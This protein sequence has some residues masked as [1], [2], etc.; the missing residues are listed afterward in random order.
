M[1]SR[2]GL[3][4]LNC[5]T[6]IK[7]AKDIPFNNREYLSCLKA[8]SPCD[9]CIDVPKP[10]DPPPEFS[11]LEFFDRYLSELRMPNSSSIQ[12]VGPLG[13][14]K[15]ILLRYLADKMRR[16]AS[17]EA[18]LV[19]EFR[20]R[21]FAATSISNRMLLA[22]FLHQLLSQKPLLFYHVQ[23]YQRLCD[24]KRL[25]TEHDLWV[26]VHLIFRHNLE[27]PVIIFI[28]DLDEWLSPPF[29]FL[30]RLVE[31]AAS[32]DST[33]KFVISSK[34]LQPLVTALPSEVVNLGNR[35]DESMDWRQVVER[36][37][38]RL[39]RDRPSCRAIENEILKRISNF[40][41][42]I[43]Q[44]FLYLKQLR[45]INALST[46]EA[47]QR[48][49]QLLPLDIP[50]V[51][52][53]IIQ[54]IHP[55]FLGWALLCL[56]WLIY[57]MRPLKIS[58]FAVA[59]AIT[60]AS[61]SSARIDN[62]IAADL[63]Y[64]LRRVLGPLIRLQTDE[65][66]LIHESVA[67]ILQSYAESH[68]ILNHADIA[69]FCLEYMLAVIN[70]APP[71]VEYESGEPLI[72]SPLTG[73]YMFLNYA[74]RHWPKHYHLA[75]PDDKL[76]QFV[77]GFLDSTSC[78]RKW[79]EMFW[80][81]QGLS[82]RLESYAATELNIACELGLLRVAE[83]LLHRE[84]HG[85]NP[86]ILDE[87][88]DLAVRSD[89]GK[90]ADLL[91]DSGARGVLALHYAARN[92][93]VEMIRRLAKNGSNLN[94]GSNFGSTPLHVS[95]QAGWLEAASVL[96]ECGADPLR[97]DTHGSTALH[98]AASRGFVDIVQLLLAAKISPNAINVYK[99]TPLGSAAFQGHKEVTRVL[100]EAGADV[101]HSDDTKLTPL[102]CA[103]GGGY[104]D[105]VEQ[106]IEF[107][108]DT[109]VLTRRGRTALHIAA[110]E[111]HLDVVK[112]LLNT[113]KTYFLLNIP[114]AVPL[115]AAARNGYFAI[116][117]ELVEA[118]INIEA[119]NEDLS[120]PLH[121]AARGGHTEIV[122]YLLGHG[123]NKN[124]RNRRGLSPLQ[125]GAMHGH[126]ST[127][128][129]LVGSVL[130]G[131]EPVL[132]YAA[133]G[134]HI[135]VVKE[136]LKYGADPNQVDEQKTTPLMAAANKGYSAV[137][138]ELLKTKAE[139]GQLNNRNETPLYLASHNGHVGIVA[140]LLGAGAVVDVRNC[141]GETPLYA[142]VAHLEVVKKLLEAH[143]DVDAPNES[144]STPLHNAAKLGNAGV[145]E[146]LLQN[147]ANPRATNESNETPLH[148][149]SWKGNVAIMKAFL[150]Y[151]ANVNAATYGGATPLHMAADKGNADAVQCLLI[152]S[153]KTEALDDDGSSPLHWAAA[154]GYSRVI[155]MLLDAGANIDVRDKESRTPLFLAARSGLLEAVK[156]LVAREAD[157]QASDEAGWCPLLRAMDNYEVSEF[158]ITSGAEVNV[159]NK[160][161]DS[162]LMM[163]AMVGPPALVELLLEHGADLNMANEDGV[164]PLGFAAENGRTENI[165]LLI[166]KGA[167]INRRGKQ[168][169]TALHLAAANG[170][171]EAMKALIEGGADLNIP[172]QGGAQPIHFATYFG[173]IPALEL[174]VAHGAD[175]TRT[176]KDGETV[177]E[178]SARRGY[179]SL[180]EWILTH[181]ADPAVSAN[182]IEALYGASEQGHLDVV[183]VLVETDQSLL[184]KRARNGLTAMD[185]ALMH[186]HEET[187]LYLLKKGANPFGPK[188]RMGSTIDLAALGCNEEFLQAL[189]PRMPNTS[190][191]GDGFE[192]LRMAVEGGSREFWRKFEPLRS[193]ASMVRDKDLWTIDVLLYQAKD[194]FTDQEPD[195]K[196]GAAC[197]YKTALPHALL[198]PSAWT[199]VEPSVEISSDGLEAKRRGMYMQLPTS[200][201]LQ[202]IS[203]NHRVS[204]KLTAI[205]DAKGLPGSA[206]A[207]HPFAPR[208]MGT[209]YFEMEILECTPKEDNEDDS[210]P[211]PP[212]I[213]I[214]LC[215]EFADLLEAL[216][217]WHP[218]SLGYHSDSGCAYEEIADDGHELE[219]GPKFG[220]GDIVGCGVN[221][222]T[223]SYYFTRNGE[224]VST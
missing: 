4:R 31:F 83:T 3:C 46:P 87:S 97:T 41:G 174:L 203:M 223:E 80:A 72:K 218:F 21:N 131:D 220:N 111:G 43:L 168:G 190:E 172:A 157:L 85:Q 127:I 213:V 1:R 11:T 199:A 224:F 200:K 171:T 103:A 48:E 13:C 106:L 100:I 123:A 169:Q 74:A 182:T 167:Q 51:C 47:L 178:L 34:N 222:N 149:A 64:D 194:P 66:H 189:L 153:A 109:A 35:D 67:D 141:K 26:F 198:V 33:F 187:A 38:S 114:T 165:R 25:W 36:E 140:Q 9:P 207:D 211:D 188:G 90:V 81:G 68:M 99:N 69:R 181:C 132:V 37:V 126:L 39:I 56:S 94:A 14:G 40:T 139:V 95:A 7:T 183:K 55:K 16:I 30:H 136:L 86:Q 177:L 18:R 180:V 206:R 150:E 27:D 70:A 98:Q 217:G 158:L 147:G 17:A 24:N 45:H 142:S 52:R 12:F 20:R 61:P 84:P 202:N 8:I 23:R 113:T 208:G 115:H 105:I 5:E 112:V 166:K 53:H 175:V 135:L 215:G 164:D 60:Q 62:F 162:P 42:P 28:D 29:F 92:G 129:S 191:D 173:N 2:L 197:Q 71:L 120:T 93:N 137:V 192:Q 76:D 54:E 170:H 15:T 204:F 138:R 148:V 19:V 59:L 10:F 116:V 119:I 216:P 185:T 221:W 176:T 184:G 117:K 50:G 193:R 212:C 179:T 134:G 143:A 201:S 102:I 107:G 133:G 32:V 89:Q 88:L 6:L 122:N 79:Y 186:G 146:L 196:R 160:R 195:A 58:E 91:L 49:L 77:L 125:I 110:C 154:A 118:G 205:L 63:E 65:V 163:A 155:T 73:P 22:S 161:G 145:V 128:K 130:P 156:E 78:R 209:S 214:G 151:G 108:A 75:P 101:N 96:L 57:A 44:P 144:D 159:V 121:T 210:I 219:C 152:W 124:A 82:T 104:A